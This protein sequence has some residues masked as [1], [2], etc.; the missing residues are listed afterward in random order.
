MGTRLIDIRLRDDWRLFNESESSRIFLEGPSQSSSHLGIHKFVYVFLPSRRPL[1]VYALASHATH[2]SSVLTPVPYFS[3]CFGNQPESA[4]RGNTS[5]VCVV[6]TGAKKRRKMRVVS[7]KD[8]SERERSSGKNFVVKRIRNP[9]KKKRKRLET[10]LLF[11][12]DGGSTGADGH[13]WRH[14]VNRRRRRGDAGLQLLNV[15]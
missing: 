4:K 2:P 8:R 11:L 7:K 15:N 3:Y 13:N 9:K 5:E 12:F 10:M 14:G 6:V 1:L